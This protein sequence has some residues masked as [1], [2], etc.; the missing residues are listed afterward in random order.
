M[1]FLLAAVVLAAATGCGTGRITEADAMSKAQ[2]IERA[3][4][5]QADDRR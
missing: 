3:N 4:P 2:E 5:V 1:K